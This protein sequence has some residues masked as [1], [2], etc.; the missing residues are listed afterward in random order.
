MKSYQITKFLELFILGALL[1][2]SVVVIDRYAAHPVVKADI[3][4]PAQQTTSQPP[5]A[6]PQVN[7]AEWP[8][9]ANGPERKGYQPVNLGN[10]FTVAWRHPFQPEK[11]YPQVQPIVYS[12]N[13]YVGTEMGNVYAFNAQTGAQVWVYAVGAPVL[14]SVAAGNSKVYFGAMDGAVYALNA[15]NGALAWKQQLSEFIGFSTAPVL[16]ENKVMLGGRNGIFY[17]LNWDN[18]SVAWQ[19]TVGSPILQ[20]AA[21]SNGRV[22]FGAMNMRVYAISSANGQ[23][24]WRTNVLAGMGFKDYWPVVF[25]GMVYI[26]P[27]TT[28][29]LG[30]EGSQY[31]QVTNYAAQKAVLDA[32]DA[33]PGNY[34][35][36]MYRIGETDGLIKKPVIHYHFQT[37]NGATAPPCVAESQ[38][39]KLVM[40]AYYPLAFY[41][42]GWGLVD[43]SESSRVMVDV[44]YDGSTRGFGNQDE[45]MSTSCASNK[46]LAFH[47]QEGNA[48]FTGFF[49]LNSRTWTQVGAGASNHEMYNNTQGGG[50]NPPV[51]V[52]GWVYHISAYNLIARR[53]T[54]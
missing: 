50:S 28:G 39:T 31:A 53:V 1:V 14:S 20:T 38:G 22:I 46:V 35:L 18:G 4:L 45:N 9:V 21:W 16:A 29:W 44:F 48:Q 19:Y 2:I 10:T 49:D 41:G 30:L 11:V 15:N 52:E 25:N 34:R 3:V 24:S 32:Y 23:L 43:V 26:R 40:P 42:S 12:G 17:A 6:D 51:I 27:V 54:P 8:Q 33:N 7:T 47:I 5:Q 37:Q 13:V 36:G